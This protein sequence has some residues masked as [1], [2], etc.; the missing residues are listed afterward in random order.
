MFINEF[1]T[2]GVPVVISPSETRTGTY[3]IDFERIESILHERGLP[4]EALD[5]VRRYFELITQ[6][7]GGS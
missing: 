4:E 5:S 3:I 6:S 1:V 2:K 7:G